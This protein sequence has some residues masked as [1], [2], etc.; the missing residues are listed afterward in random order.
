MSLDTI[1]NMSITA[2]SKAPSV[3]GFGTPLLAGFHEVWTDRR[4]KEYGSESEMLDDGFATT[5]SLYQMALAVKSQNPCPQTFKVGRRAILHVTTLDPTTHTATGDILAYVI[6]GKP[7]FFKVTVTENGSDSLVAAAVNAA[8][9]AALPGYAVTDDGDVVTI[10]APGGLVPTKAS[11]LTAGLDPLTNLATDTVLSCTVDGHAVSYT[12]LLAANGSETLVAAG[13]LAAANA[14]LASLGYVCFTDGDLVYISKP[15]GTAPTIAALVLLTNT[16]TTFSNLTVA[17]A[18][19]DPPLQSVQIIPTNLSTGFVYGGKIAGKTLSYT[20]SGG[21]AGSLANVCTALGTVLAG[22]GLAASIDVNTTDVTVT[23]TSPGVILSYAVDATLKLKDVTTDSGLAGDLAAIMD[24]DDDWY[25]LLLDTNNADSILEAAG[26]IEAHRKI[27]LVQSADWDIKDSGQTD[28]I[29]STLQLDNYSR[30]GL[31]YHDKIG[32]IAWAAA[33]MLAGR[34]AWDPG[35]E[36]WAFKDIKGVPSTKLK[37]GEESAILNKN[38]SHYTSVAKLP[39]YFEGKAGDGSFM[40][41]IRGIDWLYARIREA[42][43]RALTNNRKIPF[44]DGGVD[45]LRMVI[46]GILIQGTKVGLLADTPAPLVTA[47]KVADVDA[48]LRINRIMPDIK[49]TAQL[50]GAIHR[51]R[52]IQGTISI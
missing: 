35:I 12:V 19:I 14:A 9:T 15:N 32:G 20:V 21:D 37:T 39:I 22:L 34:L 48:S 27:C 41:T 28:D 3:E 11:L 5:D 4:V 13:L 30:T 25:G 43:F 23:A 24:E 1:I 16:P 52:G 47:P 31:M 29:A 7:F 45:A 10:R 36:T 2:L 26:V 6:D 8:A 51:L 50:A 38:A 46:M 44:T 40:D 18:T 49:F 42:V 17:A 33:G